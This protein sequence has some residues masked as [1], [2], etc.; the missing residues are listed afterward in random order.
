MP[1]LMRNRRRVI[2]WSLIGFLV[3]TLL[4]ALW[5]WASLTEWRY[6]RRLFPWS[7]YALCGTSVPRT[8]PDKVRVGLYEEFPV[9]WRLDKLEHVDFP[10]TLAIAAP[11]REEF[12]RLRDEIRETYPQVREVYFW[13]VLSHEEGYY[14]GAWSDPSGIRRLT[15]E[16]DGLPI[17]WDSELPLG[18]T[19]LS[20]ENLRSNRAFLH[21]WLMDRQSSTHIWRSHTSMG[22]NPAFLRL[23]SLHF[24]PSRYPTVSLHLD[25]YM[26]GTGAPE[27]EVFR[28][29]RCGVEKYGER[30]IPSLG[31]LND[32]E[33]PEEIF[34]PVET[35]RRNLELA[36]RAGVSEVWL[37]GANGIGEYLTVLRETMPLEDLGESS[38]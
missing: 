11:S 9:P 19:A 4:G 23:V 7:A 31:V 32:H 15:A 38:E 21:D 25:L 29:L 18:Y 33:G 13:P 1:V 37:F 35:L 12:L 20:L 28:I 6:G 24:D 34:V 17:M 30:F 10:V 27:D 5:L 14:T 36:R 2:L 3:L 8:L 22:L 26:Q 16:A